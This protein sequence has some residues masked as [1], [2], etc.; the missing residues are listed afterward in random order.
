MPTNSTRTR[1]D[2]Q[3]KDHI[4]P[5]G[6]KQS[7]HPKQSQTHNLPTDDVENINSTNKERNLLLSKKPL[8]VSVEQK[9][10]YSYL[11][12]HAS[13]RHNIKD[14]RMKENA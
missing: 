2:D 3:R 5:K 11:H 9:V 12:V 10:L 14:R 7:N 13:Q 6:P 8:F 4:D 1:M